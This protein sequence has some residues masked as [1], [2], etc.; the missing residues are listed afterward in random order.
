MPEPSTFT[1]AKTR[2][3]PRCDPVGVGHRWP[4]DFEY[5]DTCLCGAWYLLKDSRGAVKIAEADAALQALEFAH[6]AILDAIGL[7]DGLDGQAGQA[8]LRLI[9]AAL[10][11]NGRVP[12]DLPIEDDP[13]YESVDVRLDAKAARTALLTAA[14]DLDK[15]ITG[16]GQI[17]MADVVQWLKARAEDLPNG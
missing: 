3:E 8:V 14:K 1:D 10:T 7:D 6:G 12:P 5:G 9:R 16:N 13:A 17:R 15:L 11:A 2:F 4:S